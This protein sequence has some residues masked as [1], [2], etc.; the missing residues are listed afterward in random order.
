MSETAYELKHFPN[1]IIDDFATCWNYLD[2][3]SA[4]EVSNKEMW[5]YK[6]DKSHPIYAYFNDANL[7]EY[8]EM[9]PGFLNSP[10]LDR[11]RWC[12]L[13]IP[14]QHNPPHTDFFIGKHFHLAEYRSRPRRDPYFDETGEFGPTGMFKYDQGL[15]QHYDFKNPVVFSTKIPHGGTNK[16]NADYR[17]LATIT[18][19]Q[20]K[21]E[22]LL[23]ELPPEWF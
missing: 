4:I 17:V 18:F 1:H 19:G 14:I 8:Y 7:I 3:S 20:K 13:N 22:Q 16:H 11:G 5:K 23:N 9:A 15:F 6:I 21:Y 12:A 10:H 2:K